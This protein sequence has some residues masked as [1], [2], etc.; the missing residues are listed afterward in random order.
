MEERLGGGNAHEDVSELGAGG[1]A[2][3][4]DPVGSPPKAEM[5]CW[6]HSSAVMRSRR[7]LLAEPLYSEPS[8]RPEVEK[9]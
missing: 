1:L 8:K 2:P 4:G 5:L 3:Y 9:A 7:A 6:I